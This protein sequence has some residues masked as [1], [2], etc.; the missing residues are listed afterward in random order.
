MDPKII[1]FNRPV[2]VGNELEAMREA[3]DE[4]H[5]SGD[6][7][8]TQ[9]CADLLTSELGVEGVVLTTSCTDA[10]ELSAL[11]LNIGPGDEVI[12]PSFAFVSTANAFVLRGARPVFADVRPDTLNLDEER[13]EQLI[14]PRTRAIV[15][16]HYAGVACEMDRILEIGE[17]HGVPVVEDNAHGLYG[18]YRGRYLGTLGPLATQSFHETK[19][20]T[21]GEGGALLINDAVYVARAEI[22]RDKGTNRQQLF[23]GE[24]DKYTWVDL[25]SSYALSDILAAFLLA[26]LS[27]RDR[28]QS[29]R[30]EI[31]NTYHE[32]LAGLAVKHG[33]QLPHVPPECE[34][35]YHLYYMVLGDREQ[36]DALIAHLKGLGIYAVFHYTP[37][38]V[39]RMGLG[40]GGRPG[41]CPVT[42]RISDGLLRL[43]FYND[44]DERDQERV[45]AEIGSYFAKR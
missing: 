44:L 27:K 41:Q 24:V 29:R 22:L 4:M 12:V 11:L 37:L 13:L 7:R 28:I 36:R 1:P 20:F 34:Q 25:G 45:L 30:A 23:R 10:L 31:W 21:C 43:P 19:N 40:F 17:R 8:F 42:E 32:R 5:I 9:R 39:S 26:Q 15:L 38:H 14:T 6:G 18:R 2:L 3:L 33:I 35:A 16:V